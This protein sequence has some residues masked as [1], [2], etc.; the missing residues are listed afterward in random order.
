MK[1]FVSLLTTLCILFSMLGAFT[2]SAAESGTYRDTM[3]WTLNDDGVLTISGTGVVAYEHD[4][5]LPWSESIGLITE[6]ILE[7][8]ITGV[9]GEWTFAGLENL[10]SV[11]LPESITVIGYEAFMNCPVLTS[12]TI[13]AGVKEIGSRAFGIC[14]SLTEINVDENNSYYSSVDGVLFNK[15][16]TELIQFPS[17]R[18]DTTYK[19]PETVTRIGDAAF[20]YNNNLTSIV[21]PDSVKSIGMNTFNACENLADISITSSVEEIGWYAFSQTAYYNDETKWDNNVLYIDDYLI[22]AKDEISGAYEIKSGTRA[23]ADDAFSGCRNLTD[24]TIPDSVVIMGDGV[25]DNCGKL[26]EVVI[27]YGTTK[28][29]ESMFSFCT[30]LTNVTIPASVKSIEDHAFNFC[31]KLTSIELPDGVTKIGDWAFK[32]SALT[33]ITIPSGVTTIGNS[34]FQCFALTDITIPASV[35]SIGSAAFSGCAVSEIKVDAGNANYIS[36]NGVLFNIEKTELICYPK[37]KA[38]ASYTIPD[39]VITV[40]TMAFYACKNLTEISVPDSVKNINGSAFRACKGLTEFTIPKGVSVINSNVFESC[41]NLT[42]V[43]IGEGVKSIGYQAFYNCYALTA[44]TIPHSVTD[45]GESAFSYCKYLRSI[46]IG[47]GVK[48]IGGGAFNNC[49]RL[50]NVY[51]H[52]TPEDFEKISIEEYN[53]TTFTSA[54]IHYILP[55]EHTHKICGGVSCADNHEDIEWKAWYGA[56]A[57][58]T[59]TGN[60]YL[61]ED[62]KLY[63]DWLVQDGPINVCLNGHIITTREGGLYIENSV[64]LTDCT[65]EIHSFTPNKDGV[66][67]LDEEN[68]VETVSGGVVTGFADAYTIQ[69]LIV[70]S[71][72]VL[73][74]YNINITGNGESPYASDLYKGGG[75]TNN[76]IFNM[77]SGKIVGNGAGVYNFGVFNMIGGEIADNTQYGG[78]DSCDGTMTV[79]GASVIKDNKRNLYAKENCISINTDNPLKDGAYI[80]VTISDEQTEEKPVNITGA[81]NADYSKYFYSDD[82]KYKIVNGENNVI[83]L[84]YVNKIKAYMSRTF[85]SDNNIQTEKVTSL[86]QLENLLAEE[87]DY[88]KISEIY[89]E[90]FFNNKFLYLYHTDDGSSG[91]IYNIASVENAENTINISVVQETE[92][93]TDDIVRWFLIAEIDKD[94]YDKDININFTDLQG[95]TYS[96]DITEIR[97]FDNTGYPIDT[98]P[99]NEEFVLGIDVKKNVYLNEY[100][101]IIG[102]LYAPDGRLIGVYPVKIKASSNIISYA[103]HIPAQENPVGS[104]KA[105]V[106]DS[107][108]SVQ[109]LAKAKTLS[110]S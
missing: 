12:V 68:G 56:D 98:V 106:W 31:K 10:R 69:S 54:T 75:V 43:V 40:G 28:I 9:E 25:F 96:Y 16:K 81:N 45:I 18:S 62:V 13:P 49:I 52:G 109:P 38:D 32:D 95:S 84:E 92:G 51:Y 82:E 58:P 20:E 36:E 64:A 48:T 44:V 83:Q 80:G 107:F 30:E 63:D 19:F 104:I 94:L 110:F 65:D 3:T 89:N 42:S 41:E 53:N 11:T 99:Q 86:N 93:D 57:L 66:W 87:C 47:S 24:I 60:Y 39:S 76:G 29:G 21:I 85:F 26:T 59:E 90:T 91:N 8:G 1:K 46:T 67:V 105:F 4:T 101:F 71:A 74:M 73:D 108:S 23:I 7:E 77:H 72:G 33:N 27:P 14:G 102:A 34:A 15:E 22:K 35:T 5:P 6:I 55:P 97:I 78:V 79:G 88:D 37:E 100:A 61:T 70:V 50:R 2:V 103:E 17:G